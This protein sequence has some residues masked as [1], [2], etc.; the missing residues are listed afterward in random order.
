[1]AKDW[2]TVMNVNADAWG[3][4]PAVFTELDTLMLA[5]DTALAYHGEKRNHSYLCSN[6][7]V[8]GGV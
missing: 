2:K 5:A 8:Q 6:G 1:M 4:F 7:V 3:I